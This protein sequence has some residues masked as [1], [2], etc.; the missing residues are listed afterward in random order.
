MHLISDPRVKLDTT[1]SDEMYEV[2]M[3]DGVWAAYQKHGSWYAD[4]VYA[5]G[6]KLAEFGR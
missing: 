6:D 3:P 2:Q 4:A 1:V 5:L